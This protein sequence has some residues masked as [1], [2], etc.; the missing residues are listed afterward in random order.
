MLL[1]TSPVLYLPT[2]GRKQQEGR[3]IQEAAQEELLLWVVA[4]V[5]YPW[6][7]YLRAFISQGLQDL[8]ASHPTAQHCCFHIPRKIC[9]FPRPSEPWGCFQG[10]HKRKMLLHHLHGP[11]K[12]H[13]IH[14]PVS[15]MIPTS[16]SRT[17]KGVELPWQERKPHLVHNTWMDPLSPVTGEAPSH[18]LHCHCGHTH[19]CLSS[20]TC[21]NKKPLTAP[22]LPSSHP[23]F[24]ISSFPLFSNQY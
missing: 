14:K 15:R 13:I 10:V 2:D 9:C 23:G 4:F 24:S 11:E 19:D 22:P 12:L 7:A 18:P 1:K 21:P 3:S 8:A 17:P 20:S 16:S 6:A 5:G